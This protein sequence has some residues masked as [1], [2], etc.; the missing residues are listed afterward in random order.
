MPR[1]SPPQWASQSL[2][3][4]LIC[5]VFLSAER[6]HFCT[7]AKQ[8]AIKSQ[9]N[10]P[11]CFTKWNSCFLA[12][13][14]VTDVGGGCCAAA[15]S[16]PAPQGFSTVA[17]T[18]LLSAAT[19][20]E[21]IVDIH[22]FHWLCY[23]VFFLQCM[24]RPFCLIY[25]CW[26]GGEQVF[27]LRAREKHLHIC[28]FW[29][30]PAHFESINQSKVLH[31]FHCLWYNYYTS[32][33]FHSLHIFMSHTHPCVSYSE[34]CAPEP[35]H[36]YRGE[37]SGCSLTWRWA[38]DTKTG[39]KSQSPLRTPPLLTINLTMSLSEQRQNQNPSKT[40]NMTCRAVSFLS[41]DHK[42][43][44]SPIKEWIHTYIKK[45]RGL[46]LWEDE[47]WMGIKITRWQCSFL[48]KPWYL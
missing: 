12:S 16:E 7:K 40:L 42:N 22:V 45:L 6:F 35:G 10:K 17:F 3:Y 31:F 19:C 8:K 11:E 43:D 33:G 24:F 15:C 26:G 4:T 38:P 34:I 47:R 25:F 48:I 46:C 28:H 29:L 18:G 23:E 1:F 20:T 13:L 44:S 21:G 14:K 5:S 2:V 36:G 9:R 37:A 39:T 27:Q 30:C 32:T 41:R